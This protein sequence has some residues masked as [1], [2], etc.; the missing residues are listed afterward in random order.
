MRVTQ[1]IVL[2]GGKG[3]RLGAETLTTPKPLLEVAPGLRFLDVLLFELARHGLTDIILLAGHLGEAVEAAYAGK[4]VIEANVTVLRETSPQGTGGALRLATELLDPWFLMSN[5]DSLFEFNYRRLLAGLSPGIMARIALRE[6]P[7]PARYGAVTLKNG[8]ITRFQ[9]KSADLEGPALINGGVYALSRDVLRMISGPC[10]IEQDVFPKLAGA[11]RLG[12][13]AFEGYFLDIGLPDTLVQAR[14]EIP[15][16]T[17]RPCVFLDRDGVLNRD[18]GYTHLPDDLEWMPG[19]REAVRLINESGRYAIVVT[20]QAGVARGYFQE[21]TVHAFH[22]RMQ[23]ELADAGAHIDAF[24]HCPFHEQG[25]IA[26]YRITNHPDR[27]PNPGMLLRAMADW[28]IRRDGSFLV[29]DRQSDLE[30][31]ANAGVP[32]LAYSGKEPLD[33]L[34]ARALTGGA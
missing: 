29:G 25:S 17:T 24:Y 14:R 30:A 19:A 12:G 2:V 23:E 11:C 28:P 31:A 7:D 21:P 5:G 15:S 26:R 6:V 13:E 9:E 33:A 22:A 1:A 8:R 10:S 27:K 20:N 34:V 16:R 4:R 32:G 3:T 18:H